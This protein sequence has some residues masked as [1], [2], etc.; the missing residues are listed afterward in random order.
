MDPITTI[1]LVIIALVVI[2]LIAW[3]VIIYN[4]FVRL[5][6]NIKKSWANINVLLKQRNDELTKLLDTVKGYMKY[7]KTVLKDVTAAR[8]AFLNAKELPQMAK[9]DNMMSTALKSLFA[10][11]E[12][13]PKLQASENFKQLQERISGIENEL[14]DRREFYNDSVNQYNI[15]RESFPDSIIAG[16]M[17]L[18]QEQMFQIAAEETKDVKMTF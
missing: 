13:Y 4:G 17:H 6:N 12:N 8:T 18:Q 16:M 3:F 10:V 7:E 5:R 2:A 1:I 11:A 15:R 14:A 9:A